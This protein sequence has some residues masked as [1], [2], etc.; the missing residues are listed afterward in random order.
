MAVADPKEP[1]VVNE[2][3]VAEVARENDQNETVIVQLV[4]VCDDLDKLMAHQGATPSTEQL[5][6]G[7]MLAFQQCLGRVSNEDASPY[8]TTWKKVVEFL[9]S[10]WEAV[11]SAVV[12][13]Y[14]TLKRMITKIFTGFSSLRNK[15][16]RLQNAAKA[17]EENRDAGLV[18]VQRVGFMTYQGK[19]NQKGIIAGLEGIVAVG[20]E[21]SGDYAKATLEYYKR[22]DEFTVL[23]DRGDQEDINEGLNDIA[24]G[25]ITAAI[26]GSSKLRSTVMLGD[27]VFAQGEAVAKR[28]ERRASSTEGSI[29]LP[30]PPMLS[31]AEKSSSTDVSARI[32]ALDKRTMVKVTELVVECCDAAKDYRN[33]LEK[34]SDER[35]EATKRLDKMLGKT[36]RETETDSDTVKTHRRNLRKGI[37]GIEKDMAKPFKQHA[38]HAFTVGRNVLVLVERSLREHR[39]VQ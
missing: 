28:R 32:G 37:K 38:R 20:E 3:E 33:A 21:L 5:N 36:F 14:D 19:I 2:L 1:N 4:T 7:E 16:L 35:K 22:F 17:T 34:L 29:T 25:E 10:L 6:G 26:A 24:G 27:R 23:L 39:N 15:A 30:S 9:K 18:D 13:A 8:N 11:K 31:D 12:K